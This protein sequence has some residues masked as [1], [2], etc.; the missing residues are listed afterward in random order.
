MYSSFGQKMS[1]QT[2]TFNVAYINHTHTSSIFRRRLLILA[3][4]TFER[5]KPC[6]NNSLHSKR[7]SMPIK[8]LFA[9]LNNPEKY[10]IIE[11]QARN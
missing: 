8:I 4:I 10:K 9:T 3:S 7:I 5:G 6:L 11:D 1:S 2:F